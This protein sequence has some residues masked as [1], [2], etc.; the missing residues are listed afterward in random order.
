[1]KYLKW[2]TATRPRRIRQALV[3]RATRINHDGSAVIQYMGNSLHSMP[4]RP[5]PPG[6]PLSDDWTSLYGS[7]YEIKAAPNMGR[8]F[9]G[10]RLDYN[11][12]R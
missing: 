11:S 1:M 6:P 10:I 4:L 2:P 7:G 12:D 8:F 9:N 3:S 5:T